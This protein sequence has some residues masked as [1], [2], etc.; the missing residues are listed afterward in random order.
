MEKRGGFIRKTCEMNVG[1]QGR[2]DINIL[3][4]HTVN[5]IRLNVVIGS[6]KYIKCVIIYFIIYFTTLTTNFQTLKMCQKR[7]GLI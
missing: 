1:L 7:I 5:V 3:C 2:A 4:V 6:G